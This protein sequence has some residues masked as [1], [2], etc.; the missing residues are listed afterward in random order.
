MNTFDTCRVHKLALLEMRELDGCTF[1]PNAR[2]HSKAPCYRNG[3]AHQKAGTCKDGVG[4]TSKG[5][6]RDGSTNVCARLLEAGERSK[7]RR[8]EAEERKR[9][10]EEEAFA[11]DCTF[12]VRCF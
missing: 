7:E 5:Q 1:Q 3:D 2:Q 11:R 4:A 6:S 12:K 10:S 9:M 8:A